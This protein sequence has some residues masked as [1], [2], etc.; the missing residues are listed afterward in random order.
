MSEVEKRAAIT[1]STINLTVIGSRRSNIHRRKFRRPRNPKHSIPKEGISTPTHHNIYVDASS[2]SGGKVGAIGAGIHNST[3]NI[4]LLNHRASL[5]S[6]STTV[7]QASVLLDTSADT[8][9]DTSSITEGGIED[10]TVHINILPSRR[11][12]TI[13]RR[14]RPRKHKALGDHSILIDSSSNSL[15][16]KSST[17][18]GKHSAVVD[19]S[20]TSS[21]NSTESKGI[22]SS[23]INVTVV[24]PKKDKIKRSSL[25]WAGAINRRTYDAFENVRRSALGLTANV[26]FAKIVRRRK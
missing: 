18:T 11:H 8:S 26:R 9:S 1:N 22:K 24:S 17:T 23:T 2:S 15:E 16:S 13:P 20:S 14:S 3:F 21:L 25:E 5:P 4:N 7:G 19:T 10:S 6:T 12:L